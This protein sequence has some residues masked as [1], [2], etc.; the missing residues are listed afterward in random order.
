MD[1]SNESKCSVNC[2]GFNIIS[3]AKQSSENKC[4][5][6]LWCTAVREMRKTTFRA[7]RVVKD[8]GNKQTGSISY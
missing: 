3:V 8:R 1:R 7:K 6:M 5:P 2:Q 4:M